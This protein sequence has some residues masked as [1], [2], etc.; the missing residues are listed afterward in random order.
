MRKFETFVF[1]I[2]YYTIFAQSLDFSDTLKQRFNVYKSNYLQEKIFISTDRAS[3]IAGETMWFSIFVSEYESNKLVDLSKIVYI[4]LLDNQQKVVL[5]SYIKLQNGTGNGNFSIPTNINSSTYTLR[6]YTQWMKNNDK[7]FFY[8][9]DILIYNTFKNSGFKINLDT[10]GLVGN[11]FV[12]NEKIAQVFTKNISCKITKNAVSVLAKGFVLSEKNDTISKFETNKFGLARC[13]F[14]TE[15][16]NGN[17]KIIIKDENTIK[18]FPLPEPVNNELL[19][20]IEEKDPNT[21][22][23][24]LQSTAPNDVV[25]LFCHVR[26]KIIKSQKIT[27]ID[28]AANI[29]IAKSELSNGIVHFSVFNSKK[30]LITQKLYYSTNYKLSNITLNSNKN[31]YNK[32][33]IAQ[34]E[35]KNLSQIS[36]IQSISVYALDT[37]NNYEKSNIITKNNLLA[38]VEINNNISKMSQKDINLELA[39]ANWQRFGWNEIL[40]NKPKK[41]NFIPEIYDHVVSALVRDST[42]GQLAENVECFLSFP[43]KVPKTY[44]SRSNSQGIVY[45]EINA[46]KGLRDAVIQTNSVSSRKFIVEIL[47]SFSEKYSNKKIVTNIVQTTNGISL[48]QRMIDMQT[49][50]IFHHSNAKNTNFDTDSLLFFGK[51]DEKHK[52]DDYTRFSTLK[53]VLTEYVPGMAAKKRKGKYYFAIS[54]RKNKG[55]FVEQPLILLDGVPVFDADSLLKLSPLK[56]KSLQLITN[57]F[58]IGKSIFGGIASFLTYDGDLGGFPIQKNWLVFDFE[59]NQTKIDFKAPDYDLDEQKISR[60]PD[61]RNLLFWNPN[62]QLSKNQTQN[63]S[64]YT[65][66]KVGTYIVELQ[67]V[68]VDGNLIYLNSNFEVK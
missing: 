60:K 64:F 3:Y 49:N 53:E 20:K 30:E 35:V 50:T 6:A 51:P 48:Q 5:Q 23:V 56:I 63:F 36:S 17:Y 16:A 13:S 32:R 37:I 54:D 62:F 57:K 58:Y 47:S 8:T 21:L 52:L 34:I 65:S 44:V 31:T 24:L 2:F 55:F 45:F 33:E 68:D 39:I 28:N 25:Y 1:S 27:F 38:D 40:Q 29:E 10:S 59:G 41:I 26:N 11:F 12:E 19:L 14:N 9:Q 18:T 66:D 61:F 7:Q 67:G 43:S 42:T 15:L 46:I 4:E 22:Q